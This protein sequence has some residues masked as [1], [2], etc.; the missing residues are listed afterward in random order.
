[1]AFTI[2]LEVRNLIEFGRKAWTDLK[3]KESSQLTLDQINQFKNDYPAVS[4]GWGKVKFNSEN[5]EEYK[6]FA[7]KILDYFIFDIP[8][9]IFDVITKSDQSRSMLSILSS[10]HA[11]LESKGGNSLARYLGKA[12]VPQFVDDEKLYKKMLWLEWLLQQAVDLANK[13]IIVDLY[14]PIVGGP[15]EKLKSRLVAAQDFLQEYVKKH[16]E[17]MEELQKFRNSYQNELM[18]MSF[19]AAMQVMAPQSEMKEQMR[20]P[21]KSAIGMSASAATITANDQPKQIKLLVPQTV[22]ELGHSMDS[23]DDSDDVFYDA[24]EYKENANVTNNRVPN[25][26]DETR[27][28]QAQIAVLSS[29]SE[30]VQ[31]KSS[32]LQSSSF[33]KLKHDIGRAKDLI[34][35]FSTVTN[36]RELQRVLADFIASGQTVSDK[37]PVTF[38]RIDIKNSLR[39]ALTKQ[40][41]FIAYEKTKINFFGRK[42]ITHKPNEIIN[43]LNFTST[44]SDSPRV[45]Y[46]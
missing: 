5:K 2:P 30:W 35:T 3:L 32:K 31:E 12:R 28:K 24:I 11:E 29:I 43:F 25:M 10:I 33:Y 21:S 20:Q 7:A 40:F 9:F 45:A 22:V 38:S 41:C 14:V 6:D 37:T 36:M 44:Q 42:A 19:A 39:D 27:F 46:K 23:E 18:N 16:S 17:R 13:G 34:K 26:S 1:M 15:K 8:D 4:F